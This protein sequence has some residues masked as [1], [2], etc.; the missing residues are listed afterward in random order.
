VTGLSVELVN[1]SKTYEERDAQAAVPAVRNLNLGIHSGEFFTLLGPSGCGKT[2]TLRLIGGL[3]IPSS[4]EVY[5]EGKPMS[6]VPPYRRPVNIVFQNYALFPHLSVVQN[7]AFGLVVKKVPRSERERRVSEA[8]ELVRL[9]G[10]ESR[11]PAQMSGGQ[12]QRVALA[13]ALVNEPAVL[14]LDEPLGALDLKLRKQ[15]QTELKHL[16]QQ[17]GITFV[18]VTHDQEEALTMSDRIAIMDN[19]EILQVGDPIMVYEQPATRFVAD[20]VGE[21]NFLQGLVADISDKYVQVAIGENRVCAE[22]D[23]HSLALGQPVTLTVRPEKLRVTR[24][25]E[26]DAGA[27]VGLIRETVYGGADT[28]FV[29]DLACG[30]RL[31]ARQQNIGGQ[32]SSYFA[33][34]DP[35]KVLWAYED[36]RV[37][38]D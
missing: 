35:V 20:F 4:G 10:M 30:D 24:P 17:V 2:T 6:S 36:A 15:M 29:V 31:V 8:L 1:L 38:A 34:G 18:Y 22:V 26:A 3:E 28:C 33:I 19:G 14:L 27:L 5:I 37:L 13:R 7:V 21:T 12:Q 16:Q 32:D 9:S 23:G 11:K 25:E